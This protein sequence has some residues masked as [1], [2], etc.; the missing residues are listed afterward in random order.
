M[1]WDYVSEQYFTGGPAEMLTALTIVFAVMVMV[2][3]IWADY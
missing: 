3:L 1:R 2:E